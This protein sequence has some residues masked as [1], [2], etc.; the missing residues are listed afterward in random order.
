MLPIRA[1]IG[2]VVDGAESGF[3]VGILAFDPVIGGF[4]A[5]LERGAGLPA[6]D[7]F[8]EGIVTVAPGYALGG[9]QVVGALELDFADFLDVVDQGVDRDHLAGA[10]VDGRGDQARA[11]H[12]QVDAVGAVVDEHVAAGLGAIAPNVDRMLAAVL[13]FDD[14]A[15]E[16]GGRLFAAAVPGAVRAEDVVEAGNVGFQAALGGVFLAEHFGDQLFPAV[17]A[18]GHGRVGVGFL[19]GAHAG[20]ALQ[21]GVVGAGRGGEEIAP[22]PGVVGG[23]DQ[24]GVDQHAAQAFHPVALDEAHPAHIRRQVIDF[25]RAAHGFDRVF[26]LAQVHAQ[27]L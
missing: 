1:R 21:V 19:E 14:L 6:Q 12:D 22:G 13:G 16:G 17:A 24:V 10:Q 7:R 8:Y 15:A 3:A 25:G 4:E 9:I 2:S 5:G 23:L 11:V 26:F 18:L 20:V 27:A